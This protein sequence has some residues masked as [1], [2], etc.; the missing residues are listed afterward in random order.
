MEKIKMGRRRTNN[1]ID[2]VVEQVEN[3]K[4]REKARDI[5]PTTLIPSGTVMLNL[6]CSDNPFGAFRLGRIITLPGGSSSGKTILLLSA[7]AEM[8]HM[9]QFKNYRLIYDDGEEALDFD[10][11][12]LFGDELDRRIEPPAGY[13]NDDYPIYSNTVQDFEYNILRLC[14]SEE[15]FIYVMDSLDSLTSDEEME[16]EYKKALLA[17][18]NPE[19]LKELKGSYKTE[20]AKIVGETL[21]LV[22]GAIKKTRSA[23]FIIQQERDKVGAT[24][25]RKVT[26]SGGRAP[27]FYSSHQIWLTKTATLKFKERKIGNSV[28]A[29]LYKN[30]LTGKLRDTAFNIYYDYGVDSVSSCVDF[31]T[32]EKHWKKKKNTIEVPEF[33]LE[34]VQKTIVQ[35]IEEQHLER[36]LAE[37]TGEI[38]NDIEESL[39]IGRQRNFSY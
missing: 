21:R 30:K 12:Y 5:D 23:L 29:T 36:P 38:W 1:K 4:R 18:T 34:G 35:K 39:R 37:L 8:M 6:A 25:G 20:K 10:V 17:E 7:Y 22:N 26:T 19:K 16:R 27:F 2:S 13:D 3:R 11:A 32:K 14:E 24:F 15:P 33:K 31:L 9:K 28:L